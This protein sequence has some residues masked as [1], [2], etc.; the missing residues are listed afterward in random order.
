MGW[1]SIALLTVFGLSACSRLPLTTLERLTEARRLSAEM[2]V[3]FT[4]A[5]DSGNRAVMADTDEASFA[6]A[7]E[8]AAAVDNVEKD[9]T[10]LEILLHDLHFAE[11]TQLLREFARHMVNYRALERS[12]LELAVE[13]TNLKAQ[14]LSFGPGQ[15]AADAFREALRT[16]VATTGPRNMWRARALAAE[17]LAEAREIQVLQAPHIAEPNDSAITRLEERMEASK[18]AAVH[19]LDALGGFLEPLA[20]PQLALA[21]TAFDRISAV[22]EE[23]L[24]LSRRNSNVRSLA[25]ALGQ[26]RALTAGCE[27]SLGA[28]RNA[29]SRRGFEATR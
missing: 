21:R 8:A 22:N 10:A 19:A 5:A 27:E 13:N 2:A 28:M 17:A 23:V 15:A 18:E 7:R 9:S 11:E 25:L 24:M 4:K 26:K 14:R 1:V 6:F 12:I 20:T 29:L 16:A 3:Q